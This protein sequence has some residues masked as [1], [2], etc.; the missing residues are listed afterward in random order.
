M[1]NKISIRPLFL[2]FFLLLIS[3]YAIPQTL[4]L[5]STFGENGQVYTDFPFAPSNY[6]SNGR[7]IFI[8]PSGR[9]VGVGSHLQPGGKG[10]LGGVVAV[11]I[12]EAGDVDP[13]FSGGKTIEWE[14][15]KSAF[16]VDSQM[17]PDGRILR[18]T[19]YISLGN[20]ARTAK[21]VRTTADGAIDSFFA[22]LAVD[23]RPPFDPNGVPTLFKFSVANNGKIYVLVRAYSTGNYYM[24]RLHPEGDRDSSYGTGGAKFLPALSRLSDLI[25]IAK[26]FV[27]PNG[28]VVIGG[29]AG[30]SGINRTQVFF[31]R[32]D[33][34][35][36]IDRSF[37]RL[38]IMRHEFGVPVVMRDMLVQGEKYVLVGSIQNP[39]IDLLMVRS[40]WRGRLDYSFGSGGIVRD[41]YTPG[42]TDYAAAAALDD[43]GRIVIAGEADQELA[44]PS[45]FLLARYTADG[46]L[47]DG[48][49][50]TFSDT[51]DAGAADLVIQPDGKIILLGYARNPNSSIT[52]NVFAFARYTEITKVRP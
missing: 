5:D 30:G 15:F 47:V 24:L 39:D 14:G 42:G 31:A 45:C 26:I 8:Q 34:D 49:Q 41:D 48:A 36:N 1:K 6:S 38:G 19:S 33:S 27:L 16:L 29:T 12:T 52:G 46:V 21:L 23:P 44:S 25:S 37:G 13:G 32:I 18:L 43:K 50:T 3:N 22:D 10:N 11:G 40:T 4:D 7:Y 2:F 35:G 51:F 20:G 28:K 17:L 9:I